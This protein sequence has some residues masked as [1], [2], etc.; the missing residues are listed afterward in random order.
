MQKQQD[1]KIKVESLKGVKILIIGDIMLDVYEWCD[2]KRISPEAP[3][4]IASV[5][6][7]SFFLGG[8]SNVAHNAYVLG[9]SVSLVGVIGDD[10]EGSIIKQLLNEKKIE[11]DGV[12]FEIK[13][14]TTQKRRIVSGTQQLLRIDKET[15]E[16]IQSATIL[17]IMNFLANKIAEIDIIVMSDYCKGLLTDELVDF[18]INEARKSDKKILVDSKSSHLQKYFGAFAI[19]PNK[20]EAENF[21]GEKFSDDYQNLESIGFKISHM[22]NSNIVITL[23]GDGIA[24]FEGD[25]F[26]HCTTNIQQVFDVS[27]AGDTVLAVL[28]VAVGSGISLSDSA[29]LANKAAG[30][31]VGRLGTAVCESE[32]L[33]RLVNI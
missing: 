11:N 32:I 31:V 10:R 21:A 30:Y 28:A 13:R 9:A 3:V 14:K 33:K 25:N 26:K 24:T 27:G 18:I 8:A 5:T 2:V 20:N 6:E 29:V 4:P 17:R 12:I 16:D 1:K 23:G 22:L 15:T 7:E 19:K